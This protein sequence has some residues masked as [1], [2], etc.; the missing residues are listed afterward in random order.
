MKKINALLSKYKNNKLSKK[1][2]IILVV[3]FIAIIII[4]ISELDFD[5]NKS[6][7]KTYISAESD[8]CQNLENKIEEFVESIYGAGEAEVIITL[9]ENTEYIYATDDKENI[10]SGENKEDI[11]IEKNYVLIDSN[12]TDTGLL[13]K[14]IEPKIRG[15]AIACV[16]GDDV[17]VQNQ[18]YSAVS[19]VLNISTTKIS[20]SKLSDTEVNK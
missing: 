17:N 1:N 5:D 15:V 10:N 13:I 7:E 16:G 19:A 20:I 9:S 18:I 3:G 8:Y 4:F 14:T 6:K 2:I 11:S 12:N